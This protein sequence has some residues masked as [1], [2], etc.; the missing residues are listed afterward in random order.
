MSLTWNLL[1]SCSQITAGLKS[2]EGM[3]GLDIQDSFFTYM[4]GMSARL[5]V[6]AVSLVSF[7]SLQPLYMVSSYKAW[8]SLTGQVTS[9][10]VNISE[11]LDRSCKMYYDLALEVMQRHFCCILWV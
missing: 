11:Y 5:A 4:A 7:F 3:A 10:K 2:S 8:Q 9:S 1:H 6:I